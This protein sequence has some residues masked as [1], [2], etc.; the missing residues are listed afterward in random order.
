MVFPTVWIFL[1]ALKVHVQSAIMQSKLSNLSAVFRTNCESHNLIRE[2][3]GS[4]GGT[5]VRR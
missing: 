1:D 4:V 3:A 5:P 2:V